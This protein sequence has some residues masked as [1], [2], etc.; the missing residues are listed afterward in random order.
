[1]KKW[2][3]DRVFI[4]NGRMYDRG[5]FLR[6]DGIIEWT[7]PIE[8]GETHE[9]PIEECTHEDGTPILIEDGELLG[10]LQEGR[11]F[12]KGFV[13]MNEQHRLFPEQE[14]ILREQFEEI[15]FVKVPA[16]GWT[17]EEMRKVAEDLHYR[18]TWNRRNPQENPEN[19]IVFASPV[20]ALMKEVLKLSLYP[21][22]LADIPF[23][24]ERYSVLV[25]HNDKREKKEM[26][27]GRIIQTVAATGWK[28]V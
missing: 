7:E 4:R 15:E 27:D 11:R 17:L 18:A 28:L 5:Y 6:E 26:P 19:A 2:Y 25:F 10:E 8:N 21:K 22:R 14:N 24:L 1:M 13:I 23:I 16:A 20:P 9:F 12:K 3:I